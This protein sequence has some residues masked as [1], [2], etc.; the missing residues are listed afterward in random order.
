MTVVANVD[1]D[2]PEVAELVE[3]PGDHHYSRPAPDNEQ[4]K[5]VP[6][7]TVRAN[8]DR[9][10]PAESRTVTRGIVDE[11][12]GD[13]GGP[14]LIVV[15]G[16]VA[17]AVSGPSEVDGLWCGS[18]ADVDPERIEQVKRAIADQPLDEFH[19]LNH[20]ADHD[21]AV[22]IVDEGVAID[23]PVHVVHVSAA[24]DGYEVSHPRTVIV[25]GNASRLDVIET[26]AGLD[27]DA[28]TNASTTIRV[29]ADAALSYCRIETESE[30]STHIGRTTVDQFE[31][32][33]FRSTSV[34]V[35]AEIARQALDIRLHGAD[36]TSDLAGV[37]Q[38]T[39]QQRHDTGV[40]VDHLASRCV[41][42]Q[43][44]TGVIGG[45]A[46]GSFSGRIVVRPN[47]FA[48]D[49]SQSNRNL[50]L[51]PT[52]EADTRPWLEIFADDVKCVHGATVGRL[53]HDAL[54]YLR[55]R[56]IPLQQARALLVEAFVSEITDTLI[57]VSLRDHVVEAIA[58]HSANE[59]EGE[60]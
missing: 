23:V 35:G 9:A 51:T 26:F 52:A 59:S 36:A 29:G 28:F 56:G 21:V 30:G 24:G 43:R 54:F 14:R 34:M 22:V 47:T 15:N 13:H 60:A 18:L 31:R 20:A 12:A 53:D 45:H 48:T 17:S 55:S 33:A 8:L 16:R 57:P 39:G 6:I 7:K 11:L 4:W 2:A 38:P 49:A 27:G 41:S 19:A 32:S 46:R 37:Y 5:Y 1:S 50:V 3:R 44:F 25:A 40:T 58:R 42:T 10:T